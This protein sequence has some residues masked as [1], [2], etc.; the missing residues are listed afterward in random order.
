MLGLVAAPG[1]NRSGARECP[2][3]LVKDEK[4]SRPG[5]DLVCRSPDGKRVRWFRLGE[6]GLPRQSCGYENGRPEGSYAAWHDSGKLFLE[7]QF[8][9]GHKVGLWTQRDANGA[10]VATGEYR[11]GTFVA[12]A[13]VATQV[14]CDTFKP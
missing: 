9:D 5:L 14:G 11:D 13:P 10:V 7:G 2:E 6:N 12:G 3:D 1:C 4:V 8:R